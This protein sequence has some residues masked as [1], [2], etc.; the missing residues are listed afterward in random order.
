M[1]FLPGIMG[2]VVPVMIGAITND[3][4]TFSAWKFVFGLAAAIYTVCNLAYV[5]TIDGKPQPWN[6]P[7]STH[8]DVDENKEKLILDTRAE[9]EEADKP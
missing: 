4:M 8:P 5:F 7:E 2:F 3:N 9:Q 6:F 1:Y